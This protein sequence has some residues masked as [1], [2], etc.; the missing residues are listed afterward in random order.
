MGRVSTEATIENIEDL[1]AV[2]RG[3]PAP[4]QARRIVVTDT[5]VDTGATLLSVPT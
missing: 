4:D 1:G 5:L 3:L 2:K